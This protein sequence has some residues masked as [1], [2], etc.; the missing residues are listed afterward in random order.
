MFIRDRNTLHDNNVSERWDMRQA[1]TQ[2][3]LFTLGLK[4]SL[5]TRG[6]RVKKKDLKHFLDFLRQICPWFPEEGTIDKKTW[7]RVGDCFRDYY[8]SFGSEKIPVT[9]FNYW[10][11]I[12]D[13]IQN[14]SCFQ[15]LVLWKSTRLHT[16]SVLSYPSWLCYDWYG[17]GTFITVSFYVCSF[18]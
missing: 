10:S 1:F 5:K 2:Q 3:S 16:V 11:L 18:P 7:A 12:N 17:G 6:V 14:S 9:A 13:I 4:E 15:D 8:A